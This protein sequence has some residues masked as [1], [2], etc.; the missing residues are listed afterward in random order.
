MQGLG[1]ACVLD[2]VT[3]SP[4]N[5]SNLTVTAYSFKPCRFDVEPTMQAP[6]DA[7]RLAAFIGIL[8]LVAIIYAVARKRL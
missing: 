6:A 4:S 3:N 2:S 8:I 7:K 5:S 1:A